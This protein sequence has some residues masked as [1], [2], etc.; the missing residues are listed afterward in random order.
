MSS[1]KQAAANRRNATK[2]TGPTSIQGK[3][4]SA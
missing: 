3:N 1:P 2:S 4:K